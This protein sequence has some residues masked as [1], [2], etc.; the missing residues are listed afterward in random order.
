MRRKTHWIIAALL[1]TITAFL[2]ISDSYIA[3]SEPDT[4]VGQGWHQL[5]PANKPPALYD[6]AMAYD[7][8]REKVMI[9]SGGHYKHCPDTWEWNGTDWT[10]KDTN[11]PLDRREHAMVYDSGRKVIVMFGGY[12]DYSAKKQVTLDDT[13]EYDGV[14]W[15]AK[16]SRSKPP[17]MESH[18]MAYDSVREKTVLFGDGAT[19]EYDGTKWKELKPKNN[20]STRYGHGMVYDSARK[21]IVLFG[22][23]SEGKYL[24]DTWEFDG[25][26]WTL[27]S[28]FSGPCPRDKFAMAY[29]SARR[30]IVLFGGLGGESWKT[31]LQ[32]TWEY[33]GDKW[34]KIDIVNPPLPR[35]GHKMAYDSA[36]KKYIMFGGMTK[37]GET[38]CRVVDETWEYSGN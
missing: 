6:Y 24:N 20:P 12:K 22:G 17:P 32:D 28:Q 27:K 21:V 26:D 4:R 37:T 9:F 1:I 19:W 33:D 15:K 36:T 10:K 3:V 31:S 34:H 30:K 23:C 18:A 16:S 11:N 13:W 5:T 35:Y 7:S 25:K 14:N 8:R 2:I 38:T 29:D